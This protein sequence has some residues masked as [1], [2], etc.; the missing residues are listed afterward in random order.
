[1]VDFTIGSAKDFIVTS[2]KRGRIDVIQQS[3]G[4]PE[5]VGD[6][7][8][9]LP[10]LGS[11]TP[12]EWDVW[13]G[14]EADPTD[15]MLELCLLLADVDN[16]PIMASVKA[17]SIWMALQ[18]WR[19]IGTDAGPIQTA[20]HDNIDFLNPQTYTMTEMASFTQ[21]LALMVIA[22]DRGGTFQLSMLGVLTYQEDVI[23]RVFGSDNWTFDDPDGSEFADE[24]GEDASCDSSSS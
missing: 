24:W 14:Q 19:S 20:N 15:L 2:I 6:P 16:L 18:I 21:R 5:I 23:Q 13:F 17:R 4:T 1:M 22:D 9:W 10:R 8:A 11:I 3:I 7:I 12:L